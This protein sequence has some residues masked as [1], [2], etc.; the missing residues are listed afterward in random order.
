MSPLSPSCQ[1]GPVIVSSYRWLLAPPAAVDA[2][3][4]SLAA[5]RGVSKR[6]LGL[7]AARGVATADDLARFLA[8]AQ[9]GL[10]DPRL[11]PDAGAALRRVSEARARGER[12]LVYGDFDADGLTG[13][14]ILVMALRSLSLDVEP[15]VPERLGDGHGLSLR[16]IE[17]A[18][19]EGRTLIVTADCGT[20]SAAE[21]DVAAGR[22]I[23][24]LVTDHHHAARWPSGAVAV[25]NP[26]RADSRYPE[27]T[28]T[29]AGVAW[30]VAHLLIDE[31]GP[32][33]GPGSG[34]AY[35]ADA[36]VPARAGQSLPESV[37]ELADLALIG[38]VADV[39][40]IL[41]QIRLGARPGLAALLERAGV[42]RDR[43]DLDD[44]GFAIAPRLNAAG[45]VGEAAR[46]ARLLLAGDVGEAEALA[47][48]IETAN[49][50][51]R[52]MS[53]RAVAE[54]RRELGLGPGPDGSPL[55]LDQ[56]G[57]SAPA[58]AT[59]GPADL[60]A[61]LLV[62]GEWPVGIVGLIAGRLAED[63]GRPAVVATALDAEAG[64][65]RA[66]CRSG[67]GV[68]L[69]EA[70][71]ACDDLLI[72]HG[73]HAA[74][75]G[76]DISSDRWPEFAARFLQLVAAQ[77]RPSSPPELAVDLLLPADSVDY[78]L[79]REIGL[80][81]PTG[82]GN[83]P[84]MLAV[85]GLTVMR[86][87]AATGGHTQ[88]VLRRSRDVVDAVAFRRADLLAMLHEGDRIDVVAHPMS[89]QFGGF[90]SIQL[91]VIDVAAAGAQLAG[92][93]S[94]AEDGQPDLAGAVRI[95]A[96][97]REGR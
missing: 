96:A 70:L 27:R 26:A 52:E 94:S 56:A 62:R 17:R 16:A 37:R 72:R 63:L 43:L 69:A 85:T 35:A 75:A 71:V 86:V 54:A 42:A 67:G 78:A 38:T 25:V 31:L 45:R 4:E 33:S 3:C 90:E 74:A 28:L 80:L 84:P 13:L 66:S 87:R 9:E 2:A 32:G 36:A 14:S 51:R 92:S 91:E 47:A 6:L 68:N 76:F 8:P 5:E 18:A 65:L 22:G 61:A 12:V 46:A 57:V 19:D 30:K 81:A 55:T 1:T 44:I 21:I 11:L 64:T 34:P 10:H 58:A 41:E 79:I 73:G 82:P 15:Y 20:S 39:A 23:D 88:L 40:P 60:P 29:G 7:L 83:P 95:E 97:T 48:E 89:R 53:R 50:D 93:A 49:V 59:P 24:V 77:G